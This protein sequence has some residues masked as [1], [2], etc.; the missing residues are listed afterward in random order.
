MLNAF[1]SELIDLLRKQQELLDNLEASENLPSL[2]LYAEMVQSESLLKEIMQNIS[3]ITERRTDTISRI[4][5]YTSSA[6][7]AD[8]IEEIE[9]EAKGGE[10]KKKKIYRPIVTKG[11]VIKVNFSGLGSE[12]YKDHYAIVWDVKENREQLSVIPTYSYKFNTIEKSN[13]FSIGKVKNLFEH[14]GSDTL[15]SIDQVTTISRKR[16]IETEFNLIKAYLTPEQRKRIV[17][18]FRAYWVGEE[19]LYKHIIETY[20]NHLPQF[21]DLNLSLS[22]MFRPLYKREWKKVSDDLKVLSYSLYDDKDSGENFIK[23]EIRFVKMSRGD[24]KKRKSLI[25]NLI[26]H[27]GSTATAREEAKSDAY[28]KIQ[29]ETTEIS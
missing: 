20:K 11:Q 14:T 25:E 13:L 7:V 1:K 23:Y 21:D 17:D 24:N 8:D 19:T 2:S 27:K 10:M 15:V 4:K 3:E 12:L 22:H 29:E 18:G 26:N 28:K 9:I 6:K 5:M 16:I